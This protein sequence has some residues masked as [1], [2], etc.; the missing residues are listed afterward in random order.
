MT[1]AGPQTYEANPDHY[2]L[3]YGEQTRNTFVNTL[4][5]TFKFF[6][7]GSLSIIKDAILASEFNKLATAKLLDFRQRT[8]NDDEPPVTLLHGGETETVIRHSLMRLKVDQQEA[9]E[10]Q[11]RKAAEDGEELE[12]EEDQ[13]TMTNEESREEASTFQQDMTQIAD[14]L[15]FDIPQFTTKVLQGVPNK[16]LFN[17]N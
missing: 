9:L 1:G 3:E 10:A 11:R 4:E 14:F 7:D 15:C 12:E 6:W 16:S 2:V 8:N 17:L 13:I 5:S